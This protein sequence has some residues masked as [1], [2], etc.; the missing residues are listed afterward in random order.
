MNSSKF[1]KP[2]LVSSSILVN[3]QKASRMLAI[4]PRKLWQMTKDR[5]IPH[6]KL[7][8]SVRYRVADL[9]QWTQQ[10]AIPQLERTGA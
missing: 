9:E 1:I 7:G 3:S 4:C 2:D 5:Q 6:L 10:H 8:K